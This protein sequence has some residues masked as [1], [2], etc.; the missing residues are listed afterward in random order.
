[1]TARKIFRTVGP[2]LGLVLLLGALI[3][4]QYSGR[5]GAPVTPLNAHAD[6]LRAA[7]NRDA[8]KVRLILLIDPT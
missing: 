2:A 1:M 4:S 3:F 5:G 6:E 8:D 7:F